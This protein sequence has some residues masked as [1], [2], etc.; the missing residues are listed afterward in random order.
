MVS[1]RNWGLRSVG[2]TDSTANTSFTLLQRQH[3]MMAERMRRVPNILCESTTPSLIC[4]RVLQLLADA[5]AR[6]EL[7][8]DVPALLRTRIGEAAAL[9]RALG[10]PSDRTSAYRLCNRSAPCSHDQN[11][12]LNCTSRS[13]LP[14]Q[15]SRSTACGNWPPGD[16]VDVERHRWAKCGS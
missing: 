6:P 2:K 3:V 4:C 13:S 9:R 14:E 15:S 12:I 8:C 11:P 5:T 16:C 1:L 7:A 10:L